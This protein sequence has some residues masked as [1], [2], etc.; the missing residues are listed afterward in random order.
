MPY[1]APMSLEEALQDPETRRRA[2]AMI[3]MDEPVPVP[4]IG[5]GT[6]NQF[7]EP[8]GTTGTA[9]AAAPPT[10][11]LVSRYLAAQGAD[12]R[13]QR[14]NDLNEGFG[15]AAQTILGAAGIPYAR[16]RSAQPSAA[17]DVLDLERVRTVGTKKTG[18]GKP[19]GM[20]DE[21]ARA[22]VRASYP[23]APEELIANTTAAS[24]DNV[25]KDLRAKYG[26]KSREGM[27]EKTAEQ[28]AQEHKDKIRITAQ[29]L[30][31]DER[32]LE[33]AMTILGL[34]LEDSA[35]DRDARVKLAEAA[36]AAKK[37]EQT[38]GATE[39]LGGALEKT[40]APK[41]YAQYDEAQNILKRYPKDLPGLGRI[42][43]RLPDEAISTD[44]RQLRFLVGQLLSEYRKGQTGAG[45]SD[46]ERAEYGQITGLIYSGS[47]NAVRQGLDTLRRALDAR[48][49]AIKG[50]F[51][52]E[53]VKTYEERVPS[54]RRA[55]S[56]APG[57]AR[58]PPSK[59]LPAGPD[60]KPTLD[61]QDDNVSIIL[62]GKRRSVPRQNLE[63]LKKLATEKKWTLEV[64]GG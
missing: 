2:L 7:R 46:D 48:V 6:G 24:F 49:G 34:R 9:P 37:E 12:R 63:A 42:D 53:A 18:A 55:E 14:I 52:P 31:L 64:P 54:M 11:D 1:D 50:G 59:G 51:R 29:R 41:F 23:E 13:Q 27:A 30:G 21:Q 17:D 38:A 35:A 43:G 20:T 19:L 39:R 62:N 5:S 40:G 57:P 8:V 10:G 61:A 32:K 22:S 56:D 33:Q 15:N 25:M 47:D 4:P 44:G 45:M 26:V 36:A 16:G 3:G 60:G 28:R 58:V